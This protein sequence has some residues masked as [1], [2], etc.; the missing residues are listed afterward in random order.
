MCYNCTV[1]V[2]L[3]TTVCALY[4]YMH[5]ITVQWEIVKIEQYM[6]KNFTCL[7]SVNVTT[8]HYMFEICACD[9]CTVH[10]CVLHIWQLHGTY[11]RTVCVTIDNC[12]VHVKTLYETIVQYMCTN[13]TVH[14]IYLSLWH[15][16]IYVHICEN[17][18]CY[19]FKWGVSV[20][21]TDKGGLSRFWWDQNLFCVL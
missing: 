14:V 17:L 15:L 16:Y 6:C 4:I 7:R 2:L 5:V 11:M 10:V 9:N 21:E 13:C 12:T 19:C 18:L 20:A 1:D 3:I 8:V